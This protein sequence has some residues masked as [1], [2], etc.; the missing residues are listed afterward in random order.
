M[1]FINVSL[2]LPELDI[3]AL[4]QQRSIVVATKRFILPNKS[5]ALLP[6][7]ELPVGA[8]SNDWYRAEMM[9]I[10]QPSQPDENTHWAQC[11]FCQQVD[12]ERTISEVAERTIWTESALLELWR[13]HST[14]FL[15]LLR[16]YELPNAIAL[17]SRPTAEQLYRFMPASQYLEVGAQKP[18]MSDEAFAIAKKAFLQPVEASPVPKPDA[19]SKAEATSEPLTQSTEDVLSSPDWVSKISEIGN[20][21]DGYTFE[22]LVRKALIALGFSNSLG[23]AEASLDPEATGGA[24][25]LDFYANCPFPIVGECKATA[26]KTVGGDPSTQLVR[27]GLKHLERREYEASSKLIIA[28]GRVTSHANKIAVGHRM[29]IL[30]PETLQALVELKLKYAT[31]L[32]TSDLKVYLERSP[33]GVE[34]DEQ[35]KTLIQQCETDVNR[36]AEYLQQRLQVIQTVKELSAQTIHRSKKAF[37]AT[38]IRAHHNAKYQP[39]LTDDAAAEILQELSSPLSG[40]LSSKKLLGDQQQFGFLKDMSVA[41]WEKTY[42]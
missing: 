25:G 40:Y 11:V 10:L 27:L 19:S 23:K 21:S 34:A 31:A 38:E 15:S 20:S 42:A 39:L 17:T 22:K 5:F 35:I 29:N 6:G 37:I 41:S 3:A 16:V 26:T 18:L 12:D 33:F 9:S 1:T 8:H 13:D 7:R 30:R 4:V 24:G 36:R 2:C 32:E 14:L 28:A